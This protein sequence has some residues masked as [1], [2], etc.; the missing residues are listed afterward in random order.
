MFYQ[1]DKIHYKNFIKISILCEISFLIVLSACKKYCA[2]QVE[3]ILLWNF[4]R[5]SLNHFSYSRFIL[6]F[7]ISLLHQFS[8]LWI[9]YGLSKMLTLSINIRYLFEILSYLTNLANGL[10][11]LLM[12]NLYV[13]RW[14]ESYFVRGLQLIGKY[15]KSFKSY[16]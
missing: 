3:I 16:I 14:L 7:T 13:L 8:N 9:R 4:V 2:T 1:C 15:R 11:I 12:I 6:I 10:F 5:A